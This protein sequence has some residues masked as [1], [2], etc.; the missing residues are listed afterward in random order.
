MKVE[1]LST[2]ARLRAPFVSA[3]GSIESR[4]LLLLRLEDA[5]G[6]VGFGEAAPLEPYDGVSAE[7]ARAALEDCR[8]TLTRARLLDRAEILAECSRLAALP[9][10][11]AAVDLALWDLASRR[12]GQP[13]WRLLGATEG[14]PV[15]VNHTIAA[16]DRAGAAREALAAAQAG[17][18]CVKVKVGIGDDVAR[19]AA[20]R[21][22]AGADV[23]I[24]LDANGA[25]SVKE[26][27]AALRA[28][29]PTR[30]ELCEEA[31]SGLE[32]IGKLSSLTNVPLAIDESAASPGAL[33]RRV[34]SS[35]CLK[36]TRCGGITGL[37]GAAGRARAAGYD[38]YLASTLDGP[39]G[40]AAALHAA[41]V[42]RP[43][44]ASGLATLSLF[45]GRTDP[46][47]V[48][49]GR[50]ALPP[51]PGLGDGLTEWYRG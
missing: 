20:V 17:F 30:I 41:A 4:E 49:A 8:R 37:L 43:Q 42:L 39:I 12:A 16:P 22:A 28:L 23:S 27:R 45:A 29:E 40:I 5:R 46:L 34:C 14:D 36:V 44:R 31:V 33:D 51:G 13:L 18:R 19:V 21:A 50:I 38:V 3:S 6:Y 10:A 2:R 48:S 26:A 35:I 1:I 25:W 24:R 11:I 32:A 9:Q 47:P 7:R 15:E